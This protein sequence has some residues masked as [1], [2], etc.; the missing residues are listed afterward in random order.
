[1]NNKGAGQTVRMRQQIAKVLNRLHGCV[2]W[3]VPLLFAYGLNTFSQDMAHIKQDFYCSDGDDEVS[4]T[5]PCPT[6]VPPNTRA[7]S[8]QL[9][10]AGRLPYAEPIPEEYT[11]LSQPWIEVHK[12]QFIQIYDASLYWTSFGQNLPVR[13]I[14][15][16][17]LK[18]NAI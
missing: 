5:P 2:G 6:L 9:D 8:P 4:A 3:S 12:L 16:S 17:F 14:L 7:P 11:Q 13:G 18:G 15:I 1:M 10:L